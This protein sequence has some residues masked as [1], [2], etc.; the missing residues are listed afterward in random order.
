[1]VYIVVYGRLKRNCTFQS[2]SYTTIQKKLPHLK[3]LSVNF[4]QPIDID[5][6]FL[7][8]VAGDFGIR[9]FVSC[10]E[11]LQREE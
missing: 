5:R 6:S 4:P 2:L 8:I 11:N 7:S 3:D 9:V 1:M 10:F